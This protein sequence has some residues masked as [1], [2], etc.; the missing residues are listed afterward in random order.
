MLLV[1]GHENPQGEDDCRVASQTAAAAVATT[2]AMKI[3]CALTVPARSRC[4]SPSS[5]MHNIIGR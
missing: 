5:G 1:P 2:S 4:R 3:T